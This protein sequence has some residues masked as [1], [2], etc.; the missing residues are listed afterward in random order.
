MGKVARPV[1]PARQTWVQTERETHVAW[2]RLTLRN[3]RAAAVMHQLVALMDRE[4]AVAI[5]HGTLAKLVGCNERTIRR[6][7]VDLESDRWVQVIQLGQRGTV[8]AYRVNDRVAWSDYRDNLRFSSFSA[9]IVVAAEDQSE[10]ALSLDEL[11]KVPIIHPPEQALPKGEW[12]SGSQAQLPG[13]EA[14]VEGMPDAGDPDES[15]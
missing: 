1:S 12:P 10:A 15:E 11:R 14:V 8:N 2:G 9:R 7:I 4:N 3:P 6:A 5:S 13:M